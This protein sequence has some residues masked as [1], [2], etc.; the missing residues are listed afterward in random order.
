ME[1][2]GS[3]TT[4]PWSLDQRE[5]SCQEGS[6]PAVGA[7]GVI[8]SDCAW[9]SEQAPTLRSGKEVAPLFDTELVFFSPR[10]CPVPFG[11][12]ALPLTLAHRM[13]RAQF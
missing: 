12:Q 1:N 10:P 7:F 4:S 8:T 6:T 5:G 2:S 11:L 9:P 13:R 3:N